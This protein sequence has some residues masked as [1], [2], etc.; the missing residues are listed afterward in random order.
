MLLGPGRIVCPA[1]DL[2]ETLLEKNGDLSCTSAFFMLFETER[3]S[4]F[5]IADSLKFM[6]R[7]ES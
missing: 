2:V 1:L 7:S 4:G 6:K 3:E 5:R